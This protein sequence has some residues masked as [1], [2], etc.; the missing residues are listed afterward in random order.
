M[1]DIELQEVSSLNQLAQAVEDKWGTPVDDMAFRYKG[2][3]LTA[4]KH[5]KQ[6]RLALTWRDPGCDP[7]NFP[8][9]L[10]VTTLQE[11]IK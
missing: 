4:A 5:G 3:T 10:S 7:Y 2:Q 11:P 6:V 8:V 9:R 1:I